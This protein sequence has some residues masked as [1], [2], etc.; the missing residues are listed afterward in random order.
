MKISVHVAA[1]AAILVGAC[2]SEPHPWKRPLTM[3]QALAM[4]ETNVSVVESNNGIE[5]TWFASDSSATGA[6]YGLIGALVSAAMDGMMNAGPS[7]VAQELADDIADVAELDRINQ[8]FIERVKAVQIAETYNV[9]FGDIVTTQKIMLPTTPDDTVEVNVSYMLS[10]DA[11]ALK[12]VASAVYGHAAGKYL[13]PY[14][15]KSVPK[16]ELGGPLY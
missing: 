15:F 5:T 13:T 8:G 2:A 1:C 4:K 3:E 16:E 10:E 9:R 7:G 14:T 11:A 12:V 6:Q